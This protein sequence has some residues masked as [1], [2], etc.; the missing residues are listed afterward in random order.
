MKRTIAVLLV[1]LLAI[2]M[3]VF[4]GCSNETSKN[5]ERTLYYCLD[6]DI[7][8]ADP[9]FRTLTAEHNLYRQIYEPMYFV[10]HDTG[11]M[12]PRLAE[13]YT[14]S[15]DGLVYTFKIK[16]G[17][18]FHDGTEVKASDIVFTVQ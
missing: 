8:S 14:I 17:V 11:E 4:V 6:G 9:N 7:N 18:K 12:E 5:E 15:D 13:S 3:T 1:V 10:N 16:Q 2:G